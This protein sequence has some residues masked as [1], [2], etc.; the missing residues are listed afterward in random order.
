[1]SQANPKAV[2]QVQEIHHKFQQD[3]SESSEFEQDFIT[4]QIDRI[5]QYGDDTFFSEKQAAL[6]ERIH[7]ERVRGEVVAR[8]K[9]AKKVGAL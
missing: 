3:N 5:K 6:I 9:K 2:S 7:A 1:M 4:D 8:P